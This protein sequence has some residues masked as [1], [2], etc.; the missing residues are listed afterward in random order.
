MLSN[1]ANCT[2]TASSITSLPSYHGNTT[3]E[4]TT[5]PCM[6]SGF[7]NSDEAGTHH[8]FYWMFRTQDSNDTAAP[9][10]VWLNGGPGSSS[11]FGNFLENGPLMITENTTATED[12]LYVFDVH[13]N[14]QGSWAEAANMI[15]IDQPIN[16]GFSYSDTPEYLTEMS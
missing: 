10:V 8:L 7:E 5:F 16:T 1:D 12:D 15:F 3:G 4:N 11:M 13:N 9:V 2:Q 14:P 6:Y